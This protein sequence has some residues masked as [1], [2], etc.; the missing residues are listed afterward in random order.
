MTEDNP[1]TNV[2]NI[3]AAEE[4][5]TQKEVLTIAVVEVGDSKQV[6]VLVAGRQV[7]L[8]DSIQFAADGKTVGLTV[9]F[10]GL[11]EGAGPELIESYQEAVNHTKETLPWAAIRSDADPRQEAEKVE[12]EGITAEA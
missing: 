6:K 3:L 9:N 11:P 12:Q 10:V 5:V 2:E 7:G 8:L 1:N 4:E